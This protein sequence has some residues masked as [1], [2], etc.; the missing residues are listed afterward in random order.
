MP[1]LTLTS[2][3]RPLLKVSEPCV[4]QRLACITLVPEL[5]VNQVRPL[6]KSGSLVDGVASLAQTHMQAKALR[7]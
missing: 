7:I 6:M 4:L 3:L 2:A 5:E 1:M